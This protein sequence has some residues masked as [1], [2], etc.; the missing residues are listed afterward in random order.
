MQKTNLDNTKNACS[1]L[2]PLPEPQPCRTHPCI[3]HLP[4]QAICASFGVVFLIVFCVVVG[5]MLIRS[6]NFPPRALAFYQS[7]QWALP[8]LVLLIL[9]WFLLA[10]PGVIQRSDM[11]CFPQPAAVAALLP[12]ERYEGGNIV[13][14][15]GRD[16]CVRCLLWRPKV[17]KQEL[18]G[19]SFMGTFLSQLG[20]M[21]LGDAEKKPHHCRLCQRCVAAFDHHCYFFGRCIGGHWLTG[22]YVPFILLSLAGVCSIGILVVGLLQCAYINGWGRRLWTQNNEELHNH[23]RG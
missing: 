18:T 11:N 15:D 12:G 3:S 16:F 8:P 10:D 19:R 17:L 9:A 1:Q 6:T 22:N 4:R 23:F 5:E 7:V 20:K 2:P 21:L 14:I 13:G